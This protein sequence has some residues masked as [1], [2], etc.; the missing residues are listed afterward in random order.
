VGRLTEAELDERV[1]AAYAARE[2]SELAAL[3]RDLPAL[4]MSPAERSRALGQRRRELQRR[5]VQES[6]GGITAFLICLVVWTM[7]SPGGYFWPMWVALAVIVPLIRSGWRLYGPAADLDALE[8]DLERRHQLDEA[9]DEVRRR[10]VESH[11]E[12]HLG[13]P[14]RREPPPS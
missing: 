4:P 14:T 9:R 8:R 12:R 6:G 7:T 3:T 2:D 1:S 10:S 13:P 5:L 11:L